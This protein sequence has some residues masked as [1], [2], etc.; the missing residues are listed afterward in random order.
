VVVAEPVAAPVAVAVTEV[1]VAPQASAPAAPEAIVEAPVSAASGDVDEAALVAS[2][3]DLT[4]YSGEELASI[5]TELG[6]DAGKLAS[7]QKVQIAISRA[8][9]GA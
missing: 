3:G 8:K 9:A 7:K 1:A 6:L 4:I 2:L 5:A